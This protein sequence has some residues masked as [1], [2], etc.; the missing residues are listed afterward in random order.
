MWVKSLQIKNIKS[1]EDTGEI[2]FSRGINLL[3]G[4]NNA[5]KSIILKSLLGSLQQ[6]DALSSIDIRLDSNKNGEITIN[7]HDEQTS[8]DKNYSLIINTNGTPQWATDNTNSSSPPFLGSKPNHLIY[9][10]LSDRKVKTYNQSPDL[11]VSRNINL[12]FHNLVPR[13]EEIYMNP[14][15]PS[16]EKFTLRIKKY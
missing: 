16:Y 1:F 5:G 10:F 14:N 3:V 6:H 2:N 12:D 11:N 15:S 13:I 7:A 4:P 8:Q 9:P